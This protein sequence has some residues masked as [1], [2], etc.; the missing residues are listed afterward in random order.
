MGIYQ[1]VCSS[2]KQE[3]LEGDH[4]LTADTLKVA[5]YG[6]S[7]SL[8]Q[9]TTAYTAT[10]EVDESG[11]AAGGATVT[12][13]I[14]RSNGVVTVVFSSPSWTAE[15]EAEGALIYNASSGNK[16]IA[17]I[18]FGGARESV[19]GTFTVSMPSATSDYPILRLK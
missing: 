8:S 15:I 3:L 18:S 6:S 10:G 2:F 4:D 14:S 11:Y 12:A 1:G 5:L 19:S 17:V 7:A 9:N 16:A 13:T